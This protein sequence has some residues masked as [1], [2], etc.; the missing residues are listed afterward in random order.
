MRAETRRM[1][2]S[3][4]LYIVR[5]D[6]RVLGK[7]GA[8]ILNAIDRLGSL[9]ATARDLK[10]SY[11]F[12][13]NSIQRIENRLGCPVV[14]TRRG[15]TSRNSRKGGGSTRLTPLAKALLDDYQSMEKR[16]QTQIRARNPCFSSAQRYKSP[17]GTGRHINDSRGAL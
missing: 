14:V 3:F 15:G 16:L 1:H 4:R 12:V 7:G 2:Y 8:Q 11:R 13:W 10:M 5:D 9:S 17:K 6:K